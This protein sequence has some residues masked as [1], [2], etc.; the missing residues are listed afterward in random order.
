[1]EVRTQ[2]WP[3]LLRLGGRG[4]EDAGCAALG[5]SALT[6]VRGPVHVTFPFSEDRSIQDF[7][8][9]PTP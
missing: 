6:R 1:M 4:R 5:L 9:G 8:W 3:Q 2:G 7:A